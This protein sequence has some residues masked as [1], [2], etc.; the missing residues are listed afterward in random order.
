MK[1]APWPQRLL[2]HALA[3]EIVIA[4]SSAGAQ[5]STAL[6]RASKAGGSS[7]QLQAAPGPVRASL[8]T[9]T[10]TNQLVLFR[11]PRIKVR[12]RPSLRRCMHAHHAFLL[13]GR[14]RPLGD[15]TA[16]ASMLPCAGSRLLRLG[17]HLAALSLAARRSASTMAPP[18]ASW[19][20]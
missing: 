20:T 16:P 14:G 3:E 18:A 13:L 6:A 4:A 7:K 15:C 17:A 19:A 2:H 11:G 10:G 1:R 12:A 5:H 9:A 8:D